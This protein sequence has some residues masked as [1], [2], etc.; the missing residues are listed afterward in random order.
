MNLNDLIFID[1]L[2]SIDL[3]GLDRDTSRVLINDFIRDNYKLKNKFVVIIHGN[4]K[5]ILKKTTSK[6]LKENKLVKDYKIFPYNVGCTIAQID[7]TNKKIM[8]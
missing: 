8:L 5:E 3:H 7:L 1:N 6:V 2:P 4:G